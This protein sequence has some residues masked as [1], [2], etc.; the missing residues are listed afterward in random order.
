LKEALIGLAGSACI[1]LAPLLPEI[2]GGSS[3]LLK[4]AV[5]TVEGSAGASVIG[6]AAEGLVKGI[7]NTP[8]DAPYLLPIPWYKMSSDAVNSAVQIYRNYNSN[9]NTNKK[10]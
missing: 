1:F 9:S 6:G 2:I 10:K 8:P 5:I 7:T 4:S 3:V